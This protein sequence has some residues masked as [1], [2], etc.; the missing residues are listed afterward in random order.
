M[1]ANINAYVGRLAAW[2]NAGDVTGRLMSVDEIKRDKGFQ[3]TVV[4]VQL[5]DHVGRKVDSWGTF[6]W[7][8]TDKLAGDK[9]KAEFLAPVGSAYTIV[10]HFEAFDTG[11]ALMKAQVGAFVETAGVLGKGERVWMLCD[12]KQSLHVGKDELKAY[13]LSTVSYD[14]KHVHHD[15]RLVTVR[16]VCQNTLAMALGEATN[17]I[18]TIRATPN[19]QDRVIKAREALT[20]M[21]DDVK[22]LEDRLKF[23]ASRK[24]TREAL[25]SIMDRLFPKTETAVNQTR[26]ENILTEVLTAYER[27]VKVIENYESNDRNVFPEQRGSAYNL[28]NGITDYV[29]HSRGTAKGRG[30][31]ALF[32]TGDALKSKAFD[33]ITAEARK[34]PALEMASATS[35]SWADTGLGIRN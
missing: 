17:A 7:N 11:E 13:L 23:L 6:R 35:Y 27:D 1:P 2:H 9:S 16:V 22:S 12:L 15:Y 21:G 33:L 18:F 28:L 31:S 3:Y 14:G 4:K 24:V 19:A 20:A 29:D 5:R 10:H 34:M 25:G 8:F 32:G 30:E 26:R